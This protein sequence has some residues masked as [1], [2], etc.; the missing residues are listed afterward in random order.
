MTLDLEQAKKRVE[1]D[2]SK[3]IDNWTWADEKGIA[4]PAD[5]IER[6]QLLTLARDLIAEVE[7]VIGLNLIL[8]EADKIGQRE[9]AELERQL[10]CSKEIQT[11]EKKILIAEIEKRAELEARHAALLQQNVQQEQEIE[12][13]ES[14]LCKMR[15]ALSILAGLPDSKGFTHTAELHDTI[16]MS[17]FAKRSLKPAHKGSNKETL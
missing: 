15:E 5:Y 12:E 16:K 17:E 11:A 7:R 1:A 2:I 10:K 6:R 4:L 14:E 13:L 3:S 9:K 8:I